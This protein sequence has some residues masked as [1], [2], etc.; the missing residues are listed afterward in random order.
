V[1]HEI[2]AVP[3]E[4]EKLKDDLAKA[5]DPQQKATIQENLRQTEE[6]LEELKSMRVTLPTMTFDRSLIMYQKSRVVEILWLGRAHTEGDVFVYLPNEKVIASGDALQGYMPYMADGYPYDWIKTLENAERLDFDYV[7]GGHGDVM[8]GKAQFELWKSYIGDLMAETAD[9]Y[10]QGAT[11][12]EAEKSVAA[13]LQPLYA[14]KFPPR[15]FEQ[16][17]I[18]TIQKA[19][20]VV[21]ASTE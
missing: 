12:A 4:I 21:S 20:R 8:R 1:K 5:S 18:G 15:V 7:I 6:Y 2:I 3:K 19:Y 16:S 9:A 17:V 13:R 11:M 14:N 10:A